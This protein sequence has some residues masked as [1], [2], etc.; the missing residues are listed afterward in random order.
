MMKMEHIGET[1][2]IT[3]SGHLCLSMAYEL[4]AASVLFN[5]SC[6][7]YLLDLSRVDDASDGGLS[8]LAMF[9][10]RARRLGRQVRLLDCSG[11]VARR[12]AS[13]PELNRLL[14]RSGAI[15]P[16]SAFPT[17]RQ[18]RHNGAI[19]APADGR[20][21]QERQKGT[22]LGHCGPPCGARR[23]CINRH[24]ARNASSAL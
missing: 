2:R 14:R 8:L 19:A 12:I 16:G 5:D 20:S 18:Q 10:S 3:I 15:A 6:R 4:T 13:V 17:I 22:A 7:E 24:H 21:R 1:L 23:E 11:A 9:A